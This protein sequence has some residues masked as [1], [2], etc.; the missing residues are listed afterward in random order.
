[1]NKYIST[2]GDLRKVVA[3]ISTLCWVIITL[4]G[5]HFLQDLNTCLTV[6]FV[7]PIIGGVGIYFVKQAQYKAFPSKLNKIE[8]ISWTPLTYGVLIL[9]IAI[10]S[11]G[12]ASLYL[13]V[14]HSIVWIP[15]FLLINTGIQFAFYSSAIN[16]K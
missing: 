12:V 7:G 15:T 6:F 16:K 1:M 10:T 3:I 9:P 5:S 13:N 4:I 8:K 11:I 2:I 14:I